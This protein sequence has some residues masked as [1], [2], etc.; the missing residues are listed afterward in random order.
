MLLGLQV[1]EC[2]CGPLTELGK[3]S[4]EIYLMKPHEIQSGY[5]PIKPYLDKGNNRWAGAGRM[6]S[7]RVCG[8]RLRRETKDTM[9][10]IES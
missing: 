9:L 3:N 2:R 5:I 8:M 1:T 7:C 6:G 10:I 4:K